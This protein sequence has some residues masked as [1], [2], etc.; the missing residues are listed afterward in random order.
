MLS[1]IKGVE[2]K[3]I[4][5][6]SREGRFNILFCYFWV[7]LEAKGYIHA[8]I[9]MILGESVADAGVLVVSTF[10]FLL[11]LS[12]ILKKS[13]SGDFLFYVSFFFLYLFSLLISGGEQNS[14]LIENAYL[15]LFITAPMYF[16]GINAKPN[17]IFNLLYLLSALCIIGELFFSVLFQPERDYAGDQISRAYSLLPHVCMATYYV[18]KKPGILSAG[19]AL[20]GLFSMMTFGSRGAILSYFIFL[21]VYLLLNFKSN[22]KALAVALFVAVAII[23]FIEPIMQFIFSYA[24]DFNMSTRII[25]KVTEGEFGQSEGRDVIRIYLL[26]ILKDNPLQFRGIAGDCIGWVNYAHNI[27]IELC[28]DFGVV[29]GSLM[30]LLIIGHIFR[31]FAKA[32]DPIS[33]GFLLVVVCG[34]FLEQ[35]FGGPLQTSFG[36]FFLMGF[37]TQQI[38]ESKS[39]PYYFKQ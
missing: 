5:F 28:F 20:M 15:I 14:Y 29:L 3:N 10:I 1:F 27:I 16:V 26:N 38:R 2:W 24:A 30:F 25:D 35:F 7:L 8:I 39:K 4:S 11:G 21:I 31:G 33:K 12:Y 22:K 36:F 37:C 6:N 34:S 13:K 17:K 23:Y 18:F 32:Q 19:I 9:K